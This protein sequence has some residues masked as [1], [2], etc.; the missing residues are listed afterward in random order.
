MVAFLSRAAPPARGERAPKRWA[1]GPAIEGLRGRRE[2]GRRAQEGAAGW[3]GR[4]GL[5]ARTTRAAPVRSEE[6]AIELM[7]I[8]SPRP[9]I[10]AAR[11]AFGPVGI[12]GLTGVAGKGKK[13]GGFRHRRS[14]LETRAQRSPA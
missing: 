2:V 11:P 7:P 4:G 8:F 13:A 10:A 12:A 9:A 1:R 6:D 14:D 3:S 5:A